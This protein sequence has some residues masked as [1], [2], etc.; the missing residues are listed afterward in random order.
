MFNAGYKKEALDVYQKSYEVYQQKYKETIDQSDK[1]HNQKEIAVNVIKGVEAYINSIANTPKSIERQIENIIVF[2][3]NFE[4]EIQELLLECQKSEKFSKG[5]AGA[6]IAAGAGVAAFGPTAAMGIAT[7]FGTASTGTAIATLAGAAQTN[8]ALAWLGGGAL[9][10][11]GA[12]VAGG[13]AFLA[14]AGP[15]GWAIGGAALVGSGLLMNSKNKK[16]AE[17]AEEK[18]KEI[19]TETNKLEKLKM[20][21][22]EERNVVRELNDK[23]SSLCRTLCQN[24]K[25]D[26]AMF[27]NNEKDECIQLINS[28][29]TLSKKL[30]EKITC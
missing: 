22:M 3:K 11:G 19:K 7:T 17:E 5:M 24:F 12:G 1:L 28:T 30:G 23:V 2:R 4:Q 27:T 29:E 6:G 20:K 8:A 9:T 16:I 10:A 21:V 26:Y 18:T 15:V 25:N 14:M 13:N